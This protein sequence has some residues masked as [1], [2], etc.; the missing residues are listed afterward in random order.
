MEETIDTLALLFPTSNA[1]EK[2]YRKVAKAEM[3]VVL[4]MEAIKRGQSRL[5]KRHIKHF[6]FWHDRLV[7][8]KQE[9]DRSRPATIS[10]FW[11]DRRNGV[12]WWTFWVAVLVIF[13]TVFFGVIQ[14]ILSALQV[15]KAYHPSPA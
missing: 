6:K 3:H 2:W 11:I 8:L 13:L 15:Y 4:D 14:S 1:T 12:Q 10:Q 9:F 7:M 5:E